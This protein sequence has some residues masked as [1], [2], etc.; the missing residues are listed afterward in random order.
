MIIKFS[1][2]FSKKERKKQINCEIHQEP[3]MFEGDMLTP[4]KNIE[5]QGEMKAFE[6]ILELN[7]RTR[8]VL[9]ASCSRCLENFSFDVDTTINEKFTNKS[10]VENEEAILIEGDVIDIAEVV[11]N[12]IITTLPIK[13]LCSESCKGLCH[14]C[15]INLNKHTCNCENIEVDSRLEVLKSFFTDKEV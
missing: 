5:V 7:L 9:E 6:D 10:T 12:S 14:S 2:I 8:T 3:F 13:R 11:I 15:G 1:E 4:L